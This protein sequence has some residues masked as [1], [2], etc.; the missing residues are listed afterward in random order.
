MKKYLL[1]GAAVAIF[2]TSGANAATIQYKVVGVKLGNQFTQGGGGFVPDSTAT[3][4]G[5]TFSYDTVTQMLVGNQ[6]HQS[7]ASQ[8]SYL[9]Q[10]DWSIDLS[11]SQLTTSN[12]VCTFLPSDNDTCP[13]YTNGL[14]PGSA[15]ITVGNINNAT[16]GSQAT[17]KWNTL[18][19]PFASAFI[20]TTIQVVP[21]PAAVWLFGS[22]LAAIGFMR[23][24]VTA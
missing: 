16:L 7:N 2:M 23:R 13:S 11:A 18:G 4:I 9:Y 1:A 12:V 22:S 19:A 15:S 14:Q 24:R 20:S 10:A 5:G 21:V 17:L 6:Q 3:N 8:G